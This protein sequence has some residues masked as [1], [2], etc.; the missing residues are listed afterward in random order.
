M[1]TNSDNNDLS[2]N[3]PNKSA[4]RYSLFD[5]SHSLQWLKDA[6][7]YLGGSREEPPPGAALLASPWWIG[8]WW[9]ILAGLI[10]LFCGQ[11]SKFIYIDF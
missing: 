8:V 4:I 7:D 2:L 6:F 9:G 1:S 5:I 10:L 3:P 11:T